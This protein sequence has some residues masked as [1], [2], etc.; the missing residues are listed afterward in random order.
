MNEAANGVANLEVKDGEVNEE[1]VSEQSANQSKKKKKKNKNK[2]AFF[3]IYARLNILPQ[4]LLSLYQIQF[5]INTYLVVLYSFL[6]TGELKQ[7]D[8]PSVA[9]KDLFPNG[10]YPVGELMEHPIAQ[11]ERTGKNRMT[12]EEKKTL[13]SMNEDVYKEARLAAE[14]HRHTRQYMQKYIKPGMTMIEIW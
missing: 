11:D 1:T 8:P 14:A 13:D 3:V 6:G 2:G 7:T 12:S 4:L 5:F 9:I 10:N